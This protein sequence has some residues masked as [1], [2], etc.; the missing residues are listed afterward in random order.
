MRRLLSKFLTFHD[1]DASFAAQPGQDQSAAIT[2]IPVACGNADRGIL[3]D[4]R[5]YLIIRVGR[6]ASVHRSASRR[7][8]EIWLIDHILRS[9]RWIHL[10]KRQII[11]APA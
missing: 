2:L 11:A 7:L 5:E 3:C 9:P 4:G 6:S 10:P 8:L 1:I